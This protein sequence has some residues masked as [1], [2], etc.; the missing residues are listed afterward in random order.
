[1]KHTLPGTNEAHCL[2][3]GAGERYLVGGQLT[4]VI[5]R[6]ED[7]GGLLEAVVASG[8]KG[9][10]FPLHEHPVGHEAMLVLD[11]SVDLRLGADLFHLSRGDYASIPP[12]TAHGYTMRGHYSRLMAWTVNGKAALLQTTLGEPVAAGAYG[13]GDSAPLLP[14]RRSRAEADAD[15]RFLTEGQSPDGAAVSSPT[16]PDGVVPY[17]IR[18]GEGERLLAGDQLFTFLSHQGNTNGAFI[19]LTTIGPQGGPIPKHFHEKHAETFF[20]VDGRMTMWGGEDEVT[21]HPG[22]FLHVPAGT[23]HSY[24]L[25]APYTRFV[26]LLAPGLFEPFFRAMCEPFAGY[27]FPST[28][29]PVRFDRVMQRMR[30]LDLKLVDPPR[31]PSHG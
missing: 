18:A 15:V 3:D 7:T 24:R 30:E 17:V 22:D 8:R 10:E 26:G 2:P 11:G 21:L 4:T 13:P 19:A 23:I 14:D 31:P 25:D 9:A 28:P 29:G 16:A 20:C 6:P 27:V 12:G 1:M 5:A